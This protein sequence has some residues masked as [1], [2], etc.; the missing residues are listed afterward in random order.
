ML[1]EATQ[2]SIEFLAATLIDLEPFEAPLLPSREDQPIIWTDAMFERRGER[3]ASPEDGCTCVVSHTVWSP[4][5]AAFYTGERR[6]PLEML[7]LAFGERV[8]YIGQAEELAASSVYWTYGDLLRG[9]SPIHYIDNQGALAILCSGTSRSPPMGLL[10]HQTAAQQRLLQCRV[11]YEYVASKANIADL[12]SRGDIALA[13]R[14]L[15]RRF[16]VPV[17]RRD[18]EYP[19]LQAARV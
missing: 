2:D 11:W 12:P 14:L 7:E 5:R 1:S 9:T 15:R 17:W 19:P 10:S 8:T 16:G 18:I 13:A 6:V 3:L 4:A